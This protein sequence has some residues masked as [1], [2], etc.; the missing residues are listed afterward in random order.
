MTIRIPDVARRSAVVVAVLLLASAPALAQSFPLLAD[1]EEDFLP[2][3]PARSQIIT[4]ETWSAGMFLDWV[5]K[6]EDENAD[7]KYK[8]HPRITGYVNYRAHPMIRVGLSFGVNEGDIFD[9]DTGDNLGDLWAFPVFANITFTPTRP[10]VGTGRT[11]DEYGL[12]PFGVISLGVELYKF[13]SDVS[14]FD[15]DFEPFVNEDTLSIYAAGQIRTGIEFRFPQLF[16]LGASVG[17]Y[18]GAPRVD[19]STGGDSNHFQMST[20]FLGVHGELRF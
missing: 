11:D 9:K 8:E 14:G 4:E 7:L 3:I 2:V 1:D 17:Y 15:I 18:V 12:Y 5:F 13:D 16:A 6:A 10:W 20:W 19:R